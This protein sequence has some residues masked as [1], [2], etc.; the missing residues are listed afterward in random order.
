MCLALLLKRLEK[1]IG[2][3]ELR[4]GMP[5]WNVSLGPALLHVHTVRHQRKAG[6]CWLIEALTVW[7]FSLNQSYPA[8]TV[9]SMRWSRSSKEVAIMEILEPSFCT[10]KTT[11]IYDGKHAS[12]H[13]G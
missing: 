6:A 4:Y 13:V 1:G 2:R 9:S 3:G 10:C 11:A 12:E 7:R 8:Y 5:L